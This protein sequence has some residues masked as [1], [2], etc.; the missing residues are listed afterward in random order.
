MKWTRYAAFAVGVL[1]GLVFLLL[2]ETPPT[3]SMDFWEAVTLLT[4]PVTL[5]VASLVG[6]KFEKVAGW[7]LLAGA[8]A[9]AILLVVQLKPWQPGLSTMLL[10]PAI[11]CTPMLFSGLLWLVHARAHGPTGANLPMMP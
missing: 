6:L 4:G 8:A 9:T 3:W 10:L 2:L 11:F 5:I 7:W 1:S